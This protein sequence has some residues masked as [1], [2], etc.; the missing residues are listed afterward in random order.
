MRLLL[1]FLLFCA[2]LARAAE[3]PAPA[4]HDSPEAAAGALALDPAA[5]Q[6][7]ALWPGL[8][9]HGYG[10]LKAGDDDMGYS[11]MGAEVF[12]LLVGGL[13]VA[14][15]ASPD[16]KSEDTLTLQAVALGGLA[17][18]VG[19][20]AY[21]LIVAPRLAEGLNTEKGLAPAPPEGRVFPWALDFG[22][23]YGRPF[24]SSGYSGSRASASGAWAGLEWRPLDLGSLLL[25]TQLTDLYQDNRHFSLATAG[26]SLRLHP[27]SLGAVEPYLEGGAGWNVYPSAFGPWGWQGTS[28]LHA[29]LGARWRFSDM[30]S[31]DGA[32]VYQHYDSPLQAVGARLGLSLGF[33]IPSAR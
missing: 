13:G 20:W 31:L 5:I 32:A 4:V 12:G 26:L 7:Q 11:L 21:D 14:D 6:A 10:H 27:W 29:G 25:D 16:S 22:G 8:A 28:Q 1:A 33:G 23:A 18:F 30:W 24:G 17:L 2:P 3:P 19:S 15:W 9:L